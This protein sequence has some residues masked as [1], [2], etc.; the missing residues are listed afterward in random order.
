MAVTP[1][2]SR[3]ICIHHAPF[4]AVRVASVTRMLLSSVLLLLLVTLVA[5]LPTTVHAQERITPQDLY[6]GWFTTTSNKK[7]QAL[8]DVRTQSE[9]NNGHIENATLIEN[10]ASDDTVSPFPTLLGCEHCTIVVYCQSGNRAGVAIQK[11]LDL[12]FQ[13]QLLNGLGVSQFVNAGYTLVTTSDSTKAK[14]ASSETSNVC[15]NK[16]SQEKPPLSS[17]GDYVSDNDKGDENDNTEIGVPAQNKDADASGGSYS[18][19]NTKAVG[20]ALCWW[21][22]GV[23]AGIFVVLL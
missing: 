16:N 22:I 19:T 3:G 9:W 21:S 11:L 8:V 20:R 1:S 15:E 23:V 2:G 4:L 12:G 5:F 10:L 7:F 17:K 18:S 13:G 14:C 6:D